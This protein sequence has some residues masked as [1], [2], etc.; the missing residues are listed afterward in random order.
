MAFNLPAFYG[1]DVAAE[2]VECAKGGDT[3]HKQGQGVQHEEDEQ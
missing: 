3:D 2:C 1:S